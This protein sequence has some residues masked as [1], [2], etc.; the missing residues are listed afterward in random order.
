V[1]PKQKGAPRRTLPRSRARPSHLPGE[2]GLWRSAGP[3]HGEGRVPEPK[4]AEDLA[5]DVW[6]LEQMIPTPLQK[7][8]PFS[9]DYPGQDRISQGE[10]S[11]AGVASGI[12]HLIDFR[13]C[14]AMV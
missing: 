3:L 1:L 11:S 13:R 10:A 4:V 12:G 8:R 14:L 5:Y 2:V 6:L 9:L 7:K